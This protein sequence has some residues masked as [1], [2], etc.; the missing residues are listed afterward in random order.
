MALTVI[1]KHVRLAD[2]E[3]WGDVTDLGAERLEGEV[4]IF[5][6]MTSGTP[7]DAVSSG[8]FGATQGRFRMVYPFDEHATV[9]TGELQLTDESTGQTS[10]YQAGDSWFV[11][12]GTPVLWEVLSASFVKHYFAVA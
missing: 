3:P 1:E 11:T 2:L 5:G 4:R 6:R 8:Y 7:D 12:K 10:R 9:V